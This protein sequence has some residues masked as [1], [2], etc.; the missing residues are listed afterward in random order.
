MYL[1]DS[2]ATS[3]KRGSRA[4]TCLRVSHEPD[5]VLFRLCAALAAA[6]LRPVAHVDIEPLP[7]RATWDGGLIIASNHRSMLDLVIGLIAFRKWSLR[8]SVFIR[9]DFFQLPLV[10][11]FLRQI[12]GIPAARGHGSSAIRRALAVLSADGIL[13][14]TP[15]GRISPPHERTDGLGKLEP[16]VGWLAAA[17]GAPILLV[18][19]INT[20]SAWPLGARVPRVHIRA[21]KRP[22]IRLGTAWLP[23][24][25]GATKAQITGELRCSLRQLLSRLES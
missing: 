12:G 11:W 17:T 23:V 7:A 19:L 14:V 8:P 5:S 20:D 25:Q 16:G 3:L 6:A 2:A 15:E 13:A 18:G 21:S 9:G 1:E 22:V 24:T 4:A 10:G